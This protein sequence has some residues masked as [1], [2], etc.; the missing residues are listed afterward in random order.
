MVSIVIPVYNAENY[1]ENCIRSI[2]RQTY[3]EWE[4]VLIDNGST[5]GSLEICQKFAKEDERIFVFGWPKFLIFL[6]EV[7]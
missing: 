5:D 7:F 3:E 1:I 6:A 4:L 2:L